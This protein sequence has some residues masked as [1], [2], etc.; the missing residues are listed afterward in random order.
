V[1]ANLLRSELLPILP[2]LAAA[3]RPGGRAVLSGLLAAERAELEAA[4]GRVG[5]AVERAREEDDP[6]GDVWLGLVT[7]R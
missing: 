5:L 6:T 7:R 3:L 2:E 4:L 1:A